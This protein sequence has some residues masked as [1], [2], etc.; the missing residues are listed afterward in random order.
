MTWEWVAVLAIVVLAWT[1]FRVT[2]KWQ[3]VTFYRYA[4]DYVKKAVARATGIYDGD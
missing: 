2:E 3:Q 4:P 1:V